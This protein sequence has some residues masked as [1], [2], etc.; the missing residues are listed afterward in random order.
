MK[1]I[2]LLLALAAP[3]ALAGCGPD[4]NGFCNK[5]HLCDTSVD[6]AACETSCNNVGGDH[7]AEINC[8]LDSSTACSQL[9]SKC[10]LTK[11]F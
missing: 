1:R 6:V 8:V 5:L 9:Q 11:G 7:Q 10:Q 3:L 4:C 2:L